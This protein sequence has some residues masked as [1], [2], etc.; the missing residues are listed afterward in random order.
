MLLED[1]T[2]LQTIRKNIKESFLIPAL[3]LL[4]AIILLINP[5]HFL[6]MAVTIFGYGSIFLGILNLVFYFRTDEKMR[7]FNRQMFQ[8]VILLSFGVISFF[9]SNLIED[10]IYFLLGSYYLFQGANRIEL[11]VNLKS[12]TEKFWIFSLVLSFLELILAILLMINPFPEK[13]M[14]L[15]ILLCVVSV[16]FL[17]QNVVLLL[18]LREKKETSKN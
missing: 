13:N 1:Q 4:F 6:K 3:F 10:M 11:S 2:F 15:S 9:Q 8:S 12:Y 14:T 7:L 16:F 17:F 5:E 18:G